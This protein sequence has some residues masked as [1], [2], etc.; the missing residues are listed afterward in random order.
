MQWNWTQK[1]WPEFI[2][3]T[4][5]LEI[6]ENRFLQ[7]SGEVI[8]AVRH[9]DEEDRNLLRVE[10]LSEEAVKTSEIEDEV[11]DRASV[12]SSL[13]RQLGLDADNRLVKPQE[14]GISEMM[15][16]VYGSWATPLDHEALFRW[17]QPVDDGKSQIGRDR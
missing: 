13:R 9:I 1:S 12:Q 14:R 5:V 16:D 2:Y 17:A 3:D 4:A 6:Y 10:L 11:L 8:G 7:S 15:I